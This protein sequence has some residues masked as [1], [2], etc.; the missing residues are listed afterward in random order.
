MSD[1]VSQLYE[2]ALSS[3]GFARQMKLEWIDNTNDDYQACSIDG[4]RF[5]GE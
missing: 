2:R 4:Q 3:G 5:G 1:K